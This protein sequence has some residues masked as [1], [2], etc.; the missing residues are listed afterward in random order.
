VSSHDLYIV[1][2]SLSFEGNPVL[3]FTSTCLASIAEDWFSPLNDDG[4]YANLTSGAGFSI[5]LQKLRHGFLV[6]GNRFWI[7]RNVDA[8]P[9]NQR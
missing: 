7:E 3:S 9:A 6:E 4:A 2:V 8:G 1:V 5:R